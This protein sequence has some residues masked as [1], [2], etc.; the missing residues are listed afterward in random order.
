[1]APVNTPEWLAHRGTVGKVMLGDLHGLDK[2]GQPAPKGQPGELWFK[3]ASPF[4]YFND[5]ERTDE[6][7]RTEQAAR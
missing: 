3:T 6:R 7:R 4:V 1:M 2:T 5:P